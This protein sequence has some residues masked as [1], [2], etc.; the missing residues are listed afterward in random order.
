MIRNIK[1]QFKKSLYKL[2]WLDGKTKDIASEILLSSVEDI[3]RPDN[4]VQDET[5][6]N[7]VKKIVRTESIQ[8]IYLFDDVDNPSNNRKPEIYLADSDDLLK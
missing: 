4:F 2:D 1:Y 5:F 6:Y 8:N 3:P 7:K